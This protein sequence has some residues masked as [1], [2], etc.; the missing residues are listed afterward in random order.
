MKSGFCGFPF[1]VVLFL[2]CLCVDANEM[3]VL[4]IAFGCSVGFRLPKK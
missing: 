2:S 1:V 3:S 4:L